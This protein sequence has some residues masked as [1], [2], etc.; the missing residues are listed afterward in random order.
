MTM[1]PMSDDP[2]HEM[3]NHLAIVVGFAEMLLDELEEGDRRRPNVE[4][5]LS[6][7]QRAMALLPQLAVR[8]AA[9]SSRGDSGDSGPPGTER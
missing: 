3:N 9:G 6:A 1:S 8:P 2:M 7:A 4:Q 5:I